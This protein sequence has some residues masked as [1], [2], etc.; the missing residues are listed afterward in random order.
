MFTTLNGT[1]GTVSHTPLGAAARRMALVPTLLVISVF[2][3]PALGGF[4]LFD[5]SLNPTRVILL[6]AVPI[7]LLHALSSSGSRVYRKPMSDVL[8]PLTCLWI[9]L[10][11]AAVDGPE[12]ALKSGSI[13]AIEFL[14]PYAIM[15]SLLRTADELHAV[16]RVF[17]IAAAIAGL[18]GLLD[19][20]NNSFVMHDL[21][22]LTGYQFRHVAGIE[23]GLRSDNYRLGLFRATGVFAAPELFG[24]AMFTALLLCGDLEGWTRWF[25]IV[26]A[27]IGLFISFS[28]G[29]WLATVLGLGLLLYRAKIRFPGRWVALIVIGTLALVTF[30]SVKDDPFTS[31]VYHFTLDPSSGYYRIL[32]WQYAGA[33]VLQAPIFGLGIRADWDR[34][35]WMSSSSVD[36]LW[37]VLAIKFGIPG[38][39]LTLLALIGAS[40]RSSWKAGGILGGERKLAEILGI[41][42]F[43]TVFNGLT[44]H[45]FDTNFPIMSFLIGMRA[46]LG[47]IAPT[48][49]EAS[50]MSRHPR[51]VAGRNSLG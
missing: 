22:R 36:S 32:I 34:P 24:T 43:L 27:G 51:A 38:S 13:D 14:M 7:V 50:I 31:L 48:R 3:P 8:V 46:F 26:G 40:S 29:P 47:Q 10:S 39:I 25:C 37:L 17:C 1:S 21:A 23:P 49:Y 4:Y 6:I 2:I 30:L 28:S 15:R 9:I 5:L 20:F 33:D 19:V 42:T 16:V 18:L 35:E 11:V 41:I 12:V 44:V 45:Y